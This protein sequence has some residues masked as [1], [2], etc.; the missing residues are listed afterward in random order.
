[1]RLSYQIGISL[2]VGTV[3]I[4]TGLLVASDLDGTPETQIYSGVFGSACYFL[5]IRAGIKS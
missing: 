2:L 5:G 1:M 3:I 4:G